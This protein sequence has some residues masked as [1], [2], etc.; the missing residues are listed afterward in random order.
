MSGDYWRGW[1][2]G[3]TH[4]FGYGFMVGLLVGAVIALVPLGVFRHVP[5][6]HAVFCAASK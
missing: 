1:L 5:A 2:A 6:A 4:G 3:D